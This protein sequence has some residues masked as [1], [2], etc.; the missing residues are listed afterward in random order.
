MYRKI[1][2]RNNLI[3]QVE[4]IMEKTDRYRSIADFVSEA[5]RLRIEALEKQIK[6]REED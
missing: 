5:I 1:S 4:R 2:I 3:T 6:L